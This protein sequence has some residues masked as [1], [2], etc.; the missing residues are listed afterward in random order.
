VQRRQ[1]VVTLGLLLG[2]CGGQVRHAPPAPSAAPEAPLAPV[3]IAAPTTTTTQIEGAPVGPVA[4]A[5]CP[6]PVRHLPPGPP[7]WH[8]AVLVP[9]SALPAPVPAPARQAGLAAI[10]GKGMWIWKIK[11]TEAGDIAAIV[12]KASARG[13]SQLWV[14]VGDSRDGFYAA[15]TLD[16]LVP[17]AHAAGLAVVGWGFPHLYDPAGDAA[18]TAQALD[19]RSPG[20]QWLDG[21]SPD[22]ETAGEGVAVTGLRARVY[23]GLVRQ[24]SGDRPIVATVFPPTDHW[25]AA[26]PYAAIAPYVD[27]FAP[28]VYWGCR[29]PGAAATQAVSRL[30]AMA[31]VHLIGQAYNMAS[32][33]G[34]QVAPSAGE[35][36]RFLDV[37]R[38]S[39]ATGASLWDW[40]EASADEWAA[41][42]SYSWPQP[43]VPA[44]STR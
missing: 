1:V 37:A 18:W 10:D 44:G 34:R 19:W 29:E 4:L 21:F 2:A 31:P 38:R 35:I 12:S 28:M 27:A 20:G 7:P 16:A 39:G 14:R 30:S 17:A 25:L 43:A 24:G 40:Q 9:E 41:L 3:V 23:L 42:S 13:L 5:G 15:A 33:G 32:E 22:I 8:P 6:A 36:T 26:Y 11:A